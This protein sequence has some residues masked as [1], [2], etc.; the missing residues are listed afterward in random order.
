MHI[1]FEVV[2]AVDNKGKFHTGRNCCKNFNQGE[3]THRQYEV[4]LGFF[5]IEFCITATTQMPSF[6]SISSGVFSPVTSA[7]ACEKS[8]R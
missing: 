8:S 3:I 7:E 1:K 4:E 6:M 2:Q 5:H